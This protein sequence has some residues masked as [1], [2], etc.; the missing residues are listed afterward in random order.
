MSHPLQ[1]PR[2]RRER[3]V[4]RSAGRPEPPGGN[5]AGSLNG[6]SQK[7]YGGVYRP[8]CAA[9]PF[10]DSMIARRARRRHG[11][12]KSRVGIFGTAAEL[13]KIWSGKG[14]CL[15]NGRQNVGG[16][17]NAGKREATRR[18][19]AQCVKRP[20]A[21]A[22]L[23]WITSSS[24]PTRAWGSSFMPAPIQSSIRPTKPYL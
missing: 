6:A 13:Y 23:P 12:K 3:A 14:F 20:S 7:W 21:A 17:D 1:P 8:P 11:Q 18:P 15:K 16:N 9:F 24:R 4:K 19:D 5:D 22:I 10:D 2:P